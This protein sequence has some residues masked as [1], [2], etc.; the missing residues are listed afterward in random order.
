MP[1]ELWAAVQ[2][3]AHREGTNA[4]EVIRRLLTN[5]LKEPPASKE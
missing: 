5:W 1:P 4:S 3:K 2:E